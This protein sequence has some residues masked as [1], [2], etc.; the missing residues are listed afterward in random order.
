[1]SPSISRT[2][3]VSLKQQTKEAGTGWEPGADGAGG[4]QG[5]CAELPWGSRGPVN[6]C[7][8]NLRPPDGA[9]KPCPLLGGDGWQEIP[10]GPYRE[11]KLPL[12]FSLGLSFIHIP[13]PSCS[14]G[15]ED[16]AGSPPPFWRPWP[17]EATG[18]SLPAPS[19]I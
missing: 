7:S 2:A 1:M 18:L 11:D 14:P 6:K 8:R 3:G 9:S 19:L 15:G 12:S 16:A 10:P 13:H 5:S 4:I 17:E